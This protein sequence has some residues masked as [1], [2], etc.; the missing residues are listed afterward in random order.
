MAG[1]AGCD[2]RRVHR[3]SVCGR[4]LPAEEVGCVMTSTHPIFEKFAFRYAR[5]GFEVFP[6]AVGSKKPM[7]D[8]QG[9]H[10]ATSDIIQVA[11]WCR[12]FPLANIGLRTGPGSGVCAIDIDPLSGGFETERCLRAEGK[13]WPETPVQR[14]RSGGRHIILQHHAAIVTGSKR[15]GRGIDFRGAGGYIVA[16]P[17]I[18]GGRPYSWLTWP[19]RGPAPVPAWLL[20][21]LATEAAQRQAD[22]RSPAKP[23]PATLEPALERARKA[24]N[25]VPSDD[26]ETWLTVG[27]ALSGSFGNSGRDLWDAWSKQSSKYTDAGQ[28]KAWRSF[29][30][31]SRTVATIFWLRGQHSGHTP[32]YSL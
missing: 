11:E 6:L 29:K 32:I 2:K 17:S 22:K 15:L 21:H 3:L 1:V 13:T 24:L 14:T 27:M 18:V 9:L 28:A 8:S 25:F 16:A 31:A 5:K 12:K 30:G 7:R 20:D 10:A 19:A 4:N 26:R 23:L